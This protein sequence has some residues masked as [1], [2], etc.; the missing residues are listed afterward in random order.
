MNPASSACRA[1]TA[2][3]YLPHRIDIAAIVPAGLDRR[4]R[5]STLIFS[6]APPPS[7]RPADISVHDLDQVFK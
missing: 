1:R 7:G 6:P 2:I 4:Y 5:V 3:F